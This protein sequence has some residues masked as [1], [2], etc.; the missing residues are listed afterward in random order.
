MIILH[1][2]LK[3]KNPPRDIH[4][5]IH[6]GT[7]SHMGQYAKKKKKIITEKCICAHYYDNQECNNY[8]NA[9]AVDIFETN[10]LGFF[11]YPSGIQHL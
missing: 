11:S 5:H 3:D 6:I 1:F 10:S 9:V 2:V 4:V 8:L 7:Y